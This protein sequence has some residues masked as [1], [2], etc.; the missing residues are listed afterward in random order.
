M[1]FPVCSLYLT[2]NKD[3]AQKI[4]RKKINLSTSGLL[5]GGARGSNV[6]RSD[7]GGIVVLGT[8]AFFAKPLPE[9]GPC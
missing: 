8:A 2:E 3:G 4:E 7:G 5:N 9:L 6:C 1:S